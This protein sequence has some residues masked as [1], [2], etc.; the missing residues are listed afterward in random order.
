MLTWREK[1]GVFRPVRQFLYLAWQTHRGY[2]SAT[3]LLRLLRAGVPIATLWVAKLI[4]DAVV[5]ARMGRPNLSR[6]WL[7]VAVELSIVALGEVLDRGS[8]AVE[9]LFGDLCSNQINEKLIAHAGSLDLHYFEDPAFFDRLERAQRQTTG[10]IGLLT[11]LLTL[12][13]D[14]VTL[15]SLASAILFYSPWLLL[16]LIVAIVPG[17]LGEVHFSTLG[18]FV[19]VSHD[20]GAATA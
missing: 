5:A 7:L 20:A 1:F 15:V 17:F 19:V 13:Q 11:Q 8:A 2:A 4:I 14:S 18:V 3:V 10:R 12:G 6:L 9:A 16:L